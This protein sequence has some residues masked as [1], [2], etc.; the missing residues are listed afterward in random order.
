MPL[1][2]L[3]ARRGVLQ[4]R[5]VTVFTANLIRPPTVGVAIW[6]ARVWSPDTMEH[7]GPCN[8]CDDNPTHI[9]SMPFRQE[10]AQIS[11]SA[12]S[13]VGYP[14][15]ILCRL[16]GYFQAHTMGLQTFHRQ[17]HLAKSLDGG[18]SGVDKS[19]TFDPLDDNICD[20]ISKSRSG[21]FKWHQSGS[22]HTEGRHGETYLHLVVSFALLVL[23]GLASRHNLRKFNFR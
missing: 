6:I 12:V 10:S 19:C 9:S 8:I 22:S 5:Q 21:A 11:S 18:C 7:F 4:P 23:R 3:L 13:T 17:Q 14:G 2:L 1:T 20:T 16:A 15:N